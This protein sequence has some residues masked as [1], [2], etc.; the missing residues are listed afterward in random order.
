MHPV[1]A[2]VAAATRDDTELRHT[3]RLAAAVDRLREDLGCVPLNEVLL[4]SLSHGKLAVP[5]HCLWLPML[6][7]RSVSLTL[8]TSHCS[9]SSLFLS[10]S[11]R[12][13]ISTSVYLSILSLLRYIS[14]ALCL[15]PGS[16]SVLL[17]LYVPLFLP[18]SLHSLSAST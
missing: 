15:F 5:S 8:F 3:L 10:R 6:A 2:A 18:V 1:D 9:R 13:S 4:F 11:L 16:L 17:S 12:L 14:F 7:P